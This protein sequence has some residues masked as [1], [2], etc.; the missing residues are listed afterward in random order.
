MSVDDLAAQILGGPPVEGVTFLGGEPFS[1]AA[2]LAEL[3]SVLRK[4]GHSIVTFT[5]YYLEHLIDHASQDWL[6]LLKV[7]DLLIDGPFVKSKLDLSRPWIGSSNQRYHFLTDRYSESAVLSETS[8]K[9]EVRL[10]TSGEVS[11][12]GILRSSD[13][14]ILVDRLAVPSPNQ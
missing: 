2:G 13:L 5:G 1:Q 7:T 11:I 3:G 8:N 6:D 10:S 14:D 9:I 4:N 12:N